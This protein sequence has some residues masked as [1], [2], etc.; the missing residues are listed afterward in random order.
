MD[1]VPLR[2]GH[3]PQPRLPDQA[4]GP[5]SSMKTARIGR[6]DFKKGGEALRGKDVTEAFRVKEKDIR[7]VM[8]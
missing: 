3:V 2:M 4:T 6:K 1:N 8:K 5:V 7:R